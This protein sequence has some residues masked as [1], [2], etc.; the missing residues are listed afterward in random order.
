MVAVAPSAVQ[1][2]RQEPARK[3]PA[4]ARDGL[5]QWL[6]MGGMATVGMNAIRVGG[7]TISDGFFLGCALLIVVL[8]F[9]QSYRQVATSSARRGS[10]AI[11]LG[12]LTLSTGALLATMLRSQDPVGSSTA[13][14]RVWYIV[15]IWFWT[16]R[17]VT[18]SFNTLKRLVLAA[19]VGG[20]IHAL[21]AIWQDV[22]GANMVY[23]TWGRSV[24]W[25]D[26]FGDLAMALGSLVPI[27]VM[28]P[29]TRGRS[30]ANI[31]RLT[32]I[33]VLLGGLG[34]SGSITVM[35][36]SLI[37]VGVAL[38]TPRLV[39]GRQRTMK[40][41]VP[42]AAG[43]VVVGSLFLGVVDLPVLTRFNALMAGNSY[44]ATSAESRVAM[45]KVAVD[46]AVHSPLIGVGLDY[47]SGVDANAY[48][49]GPQGTGLEIH[50]VY[51]RLL[52]EAGLLGMLGALLVIYV[53]YRQVIQVAR[54]TRN[55]AVAW[56]PAGVLGSMV[57][58]SV[59]VMFGPVLFSRI[60]WLPMAIG[61][62]LFG[63]ARSGGLDAA[64][65]RDTASA[66]TA[67]VAG[68]NGSLG[69]VAGE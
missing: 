51:L 63:L 44:E 15:T 10:P 11:M 22:S 57:A 42:L 24:G 7:W 61:T 20:F 39:G 58:I 50:N 53:V 35:A 59:A 9:N 67:A 30:R 27:V 32:A 13:L 38:V 3:Q 21:F 18:T 40:P 28:W 33:L 49:T 8:L 14:I 56:L 66:A 2:T 6:A 1:P 25:A 62:T 68:S 69:P 23:P 46:G 31:L 65:H 37:G 43:A 34:A 17:S 54:F 19:L 47:K 60:S 12:L 55:T 26:H 48:N 45:Y 41:W 36:A 16:L 4:P 52:F 5:A 29:T 64:M